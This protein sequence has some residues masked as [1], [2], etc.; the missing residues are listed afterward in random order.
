MTSFACSA[1]SG[2]SSA[3]VGTSTTTRS[4]EVAAT[5]AHAAALGD[6]CPPGELSPRL[7]PPQGEL[8]EFIA[9]RDASSAA[10]GPTRANKAAAVHP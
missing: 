8:G 9:L 5:A 7:D 4:G 6:S 2:S 3:G 10:Q 1:A